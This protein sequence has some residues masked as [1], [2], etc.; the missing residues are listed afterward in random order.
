ANWIGFEI[1]DAKDGVKYRTAFVT[2]L[3]V[4]KANVAEIA[5]CGRARWKI[6]NESFNVLTKPRLRTRTQFRAW[7]DLSGHDARRPQHPRLRLAHRARPHRAALA[8]GQRSGPKANQLLRLCRN[9]DE[10]RGLPRLARTP[11]SPRHLHHPAPPPLR[12]KKRMRTNPRGTFRI[13]G[14][15]HGRLPPVG[16]NGV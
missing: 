12:P 5:D 13:A 8:Q 10:L 1:L 14:D 6:E 11:R 15:R 9:L 7:R 16:G 3:P 2:S 4:T